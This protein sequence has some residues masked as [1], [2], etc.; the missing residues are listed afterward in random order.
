MGAPHLARKLPRGI[1]HHA[2]AA[3]CP[4]PPDRA[5]YRLNREIRRVASEGRYNIHE[6]AGGGGARV[7]SV[8]CSFRFPLQEDL[9]GGH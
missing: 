6:I 2:L 7:L 5:T 1:R 4:E 9:R 8:C 3:S